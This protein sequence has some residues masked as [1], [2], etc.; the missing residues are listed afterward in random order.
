MSA[1]KTSATSSSSTTPPVLPSLSGSRPDLKILLI[2]FEACGGLA[3]GYIRVLLMWAALQPQIWLEASWLFQNWGFNWRESFSI[4]APPPAGGYKAPKSVT[5]F[6]FLLYKLEYHVVLFF[7]LLLFS[8]VSILFSTFLSWYLFYCLHC[9]YFSLPSSAYNTLYLF[10]VSISCFYLSFMLWLL[11]ALYSC[12]IY[13][14]PCG[15]FDLLLL[16]S[17]HSLIFRVS[18]PVVWAPFLSGPQLLSYSVFIISLSFV[19]CSR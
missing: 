6:K 15:L 10:F 18:L 14:S 16:Q 13:S 17:F 12:F 5:T 7:L 1:T 9:F 8:F 4:R 19:L 3:P 11:S 2:T